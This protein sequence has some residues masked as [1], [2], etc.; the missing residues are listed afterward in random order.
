M[1]NTKLNRIFCPTVWTL[2]SSLAPATR[3]EGGPRLTC[4][5]GTGTRSPRSYHT[6]PGWPAPRRCSGDTAA[7]PWTPGSS[8]R[9]RRTQSSGWTPRWAAAGRSSPP[10]GPG[11]AAP[12]WPC[13]SG[14][15]WREGEGVLHTLDFHKEDFNLFS[16][17]C[18]K[19]GRVSAVNTDFKLMGKT[20]F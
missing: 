10:S 6:L 9:S 5:C 19:Q 13:A 18:S 20:L 8:R 17:L 16:A 1:N 14:P 4:T 11:S 12:S 15:A 7:S 3:P 2:V